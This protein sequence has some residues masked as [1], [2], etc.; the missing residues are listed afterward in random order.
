M[1]CGPGVNSMFAIAAASST[2]PAMRAAVSSGSRPLAP[3]PGVKKST[4]TDVDVTTLVC[5]VVSGTG[6]IG[7]TCSTPPTVKTTRSVKNSRVNGSV[8]TVTT[9]L[10]YPLIVTHPMPT[11]PAPAFPISANRAGSVVSGELENS[12]NPVLRLLHT[13]AANGVFPANSRRARPSIITPAAGNPG[14]SSPPV[15]VSTPAA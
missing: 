13:T 10:L 3:P 4:S 9:I 7:L 15:Y 6:Q 8:P 12:L 5:G 1:P 11:V 2:S 14:R